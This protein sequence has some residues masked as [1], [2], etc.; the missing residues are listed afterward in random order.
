M[1]VEREVHIHAPE[2]IA[3]LLLSSLT[4]NL[5]ANGARRSGLSDTEPTAVPN[6]VERTAGL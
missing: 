1:S 5:F 6:L 3:L 2:L 4:C